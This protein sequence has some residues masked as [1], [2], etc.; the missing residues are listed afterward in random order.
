MKRITLFFL[1]VCFIATLIGPAL[2]DIRLYICTADSEGAEIAQPIKGA[3]V[4]MV[5]DI[6]GNGKPLVAKY[7]SDANG[8]V[9][10]GTTKQYIN[11][12][13][14]LTAYAKPSI[15][16]KLTGL[17][18]AAFANYYAPSTKVFKMWDKEDDY[19]TFIY[20][21]PM[22]M[23]SA[24]LQYRLDVKKLPQQVGKVKLGV[25]ALKTTT[26]TR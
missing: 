7:K 19:I 10:I 16:S 18:A 11:K 21:K 20:L 25:K 2:A 14:I 9:S 3:M 6:Y 8:L 13:I 12:E 5:V 22:K 15:S 24:D 4:E 17:T 23:I 1:A 26:K